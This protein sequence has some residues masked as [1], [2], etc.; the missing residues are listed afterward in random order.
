MICD[1]SSHATSVV[2]SVTA[3]SLGRSLSYWRL[4]EPVRPRFREM[5][6]FKLILDNETSWPKGKRIAKKGVVYVQS[7]L[8]SS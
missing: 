8:L 7:L 1:S 5:F 2:V 4:F 6:S 3:I